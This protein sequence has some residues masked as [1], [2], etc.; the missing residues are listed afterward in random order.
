VAYIPIQLKKHE[1]N[2][3]TYLLPGTISKI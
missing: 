3:L 2:L 1:L